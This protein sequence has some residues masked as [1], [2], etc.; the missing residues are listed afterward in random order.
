MTTAHDQSA[1]DQTVLQE[2][3]GR[4]IGDLG[5]TL[6]AALVVIGDRLGLYRAMAD[7]APV[8]AEELASRTGTAPAYLRHWLANQAAGGYVDYDRASQTYSMT[9]EQV[10]ALADEDGP[11]FFAGSMQLALGV[12]RDVPA[13]EERFRTGAGFGWHEHDADL[14]EG[15]E[16]F[17]RPGYV[18]NL[19]SGW[20]PA[21]DGVAAGLTAGAAVA[22][23]GCG[24]GATTILM[25]QAFPASVFLG[26]DYHEGSVR[27][28]RRRAAAAGVADRVRFEAADAS[29]LAAGAYDLVTMFDCLHDMGDPGEAARAARQALRPDGTLMVVEPAAGDHVEDNLHALG[30]VFYAASALICTPCSLAQPGGTALGPQAGPARLTALL[31]GAGFGRVRLAAQS[32]VNLVFEARP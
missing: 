16:R 9:P 11:A 3:L 30:R 5:A 6:S 28:A 21:L 12:L 17:F 7:G 18:A 24:H 27:V 29:E 22:D 25:A 19:V 13:I 14:F 32:P 20:L 31:T 23:V 4:A 15:T 2:F 1:V 8:T 26:T 10:L